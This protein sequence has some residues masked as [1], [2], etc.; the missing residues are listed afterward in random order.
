MRRPAGTRLVGYGVVLE[1]LGL[2][3]V[4]GLYTAAQHEQIWTW[5]PARRPQDRHEMEQQVRRAFEDPARLPFAVLAE[6]QVVGTS[7]YGD[8]DLDV[9]GLEIGWTWYVPRLWATTVNP[10]CKLLLLEHA[11][12][13]LGAARISLKTDG[14]NA[15]SQAAIRKL[16]ATYDGTLRHHRLRADGSV[17]DSAYF[18]I[19]AS[20]WPTVRA[21]LLARLS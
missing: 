2:Q 10:A 20:E 4:D 11:F 13:E 14:L 3:H 16:G 21:G 15:R 5:L 6:E 17:R 8:I 18:S 7:S 1:P 9:A 12:E 19:L